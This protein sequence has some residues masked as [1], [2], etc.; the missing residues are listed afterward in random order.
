MKTIKT[1]K[2]QPTIADEPIQSVT[3]EIDTE[4]PD[5]DNLRSQAVAFLIV[6]TELEDALYHSLPGGVYDRLVG[7]MLQRKSSHFI[8]AHGESDERATR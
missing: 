4:G 2:A 5:Y 6:A 7:L 8:V 3:I 1:L